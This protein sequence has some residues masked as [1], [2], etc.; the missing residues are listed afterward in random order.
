MTVGYFFG[1]CS[2][3]CCCGDDCC[4][5]IQGF[6]LCGPGEEGG[7]TWVL[8]SGSGKFT[9]PGEGYYTLDTG[10]EQYRFDIRWFPH[11]SCGKLRFV[12]RSRIDVEGGAY[13]EIEWGTYDLDPD[14]EEFVYGGSSV[15]QCPTALSA[16]VEPTIDESSPAPELEPLGLDAYGYSCDCSLM[17]TCWLFEFD[18]E[19]LSL[20]FWETGGAIGTQWIP[21]T[22]NQVLWVDVSD[23]SNDRRTCEDGNAVDEANPGP[24]GW[25]IT[26]PGAF[27]AAGNVE[28]G[29]CLEGYALNLRSDMTGADFNPIGGEGVNP[30]T[31]EED[32][33]GFIPAGGANE[34][35]IR[36]TIT[37]TRISPSKKGDCDCD[38]FP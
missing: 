11:G 5:T 6:S 13:K 8:V 15:G 25:S 27:S 31:V 24:P 3:H 30:F 26:I 4:V 23:N 14:D 22:G 21:Y 34:T 38:P 28:A 36:G 2:C 10:T 17:D 7:E 19:F 37:V 1:H 18:I 35:T 12:A 16:E 29:D 9:E 20:V 32:L 33:T